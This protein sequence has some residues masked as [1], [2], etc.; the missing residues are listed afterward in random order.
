[1]RERGEKKIAVP[2]FLSPIDA[3]LRGPQPATP[4]V[5]FGRCVVLIAGGGMLYGAVMGS[6]GGWG[7]GRFW[8][9][10]FAAVKVP[11]LLLATFGLTLPSYFVLNTLL[12]LRADFAAVLRAVGVAQAGIA[13]VLAAL[14]PYTA[15]W[16]LTSG[17]YQ[18]AILFNALMFG[19]ASVAAQALLRRH[20]R[21]LIARDPRHRRLLRGWIALYAFVGIQ[22]GW[23]LRPF[24]GDPA[25]PVRFF[26]EDTW[27]NAY[28]KVFD[29]VV[30]VLSR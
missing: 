3:L 5:S 29:M 21:P 9:A 6:F 7:E 18:E 28:L 8:Q 27:G 2:Q 16:Y 30:E 26:R 22:M 4:G 20:Y 1:L 12:G 15:L 17:D 14:A 13:V 23:V 24:V 11:L 25:Q 19:T 10:V